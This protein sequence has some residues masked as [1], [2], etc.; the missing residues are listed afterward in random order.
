MNITLLIA[1]AGC[2]TGVLSLIIEAASFL[3]ERTHIETGT[4]SP[5]EN[6]IH[7]QVYRDGDDETTVFK[8]FLNLQMINTGGRYAI[9]QDV[10]MI[11]PG[12]KGKKTDDMVAY[13]SVYSR[14]PWKYCDGKKLPEP[15]KVHLPAALPSG[16]IFEACFV[17]T[18][19]DMPCYHTE[20][21]FLKPVLCI[22][23]ADGKMIETPVEAIVARKG[24]LVYTD[25]A[26]DKKYSM[27]TEGVTE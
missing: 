16:G 10:Y 24:A 15:D 26:E 23:M 7:K 3:S 2:I 25:S 27:D 9:I 18:D 6:M 20:D 17:F 1:I 13:H 14:T 21:I 11:R 4:F 8:C 19:M 12:C 5:L 22:V